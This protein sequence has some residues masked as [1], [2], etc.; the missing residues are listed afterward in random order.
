MNTP[1]TYSPTL[2]AIIDVDGNRV[3]ACESDAIGAALVSAANTIVML[4]KTMLPV[5]LIGHLALADATASQQ[6][7]KAAYALYGA[8]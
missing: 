1:L 5:N 2:G 8:A 3:A 4:E 7:V 6:T